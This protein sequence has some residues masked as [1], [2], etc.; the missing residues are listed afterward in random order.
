MCMLSVFLQVP[1]ATKSLFAISNDIRSSL[2][3]CKP[4]GFDSHALDSVTDSPGSGSVL[5][6]L[7][8]C[9]LPFSS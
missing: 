1:F 2:V 6:Q 3:E 4:F 9:V 8:P 7:L 5:L